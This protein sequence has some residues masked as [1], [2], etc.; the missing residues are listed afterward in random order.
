MAWIDYEISRTFYPLSQARRLRGHQ[1]R[2][3][4]RK[5]FV[6]LIRSQGCAS[7][8]AHIRTQSI[9]LTRFFEKPPSDAKPDPDPVVP[10]LNEK[11]AP[12]TSLNSSFVSHTLTL[13][14]L[15]T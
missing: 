11:L 15:P 10:D 3:E 12:T 9:I 13:T 6:Q 7:V 1:G 8:L 5:R 4:V 14:I 2:D